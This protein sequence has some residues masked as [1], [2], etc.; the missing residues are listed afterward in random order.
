MKF[1]HLYSHRIIRFRRWSGKAYAAFCSIGRQVTIGQL[2][3]GIAEASLNKQRG[4][5]SIIG[6]EGCG[7]AEHKVSDEDTGTLLSDLQQLI[8]TILLPQTAMVDGCG[9]IASRYIKKKLGK[10][11]ECRICVCSASSLY[12]THK[13]C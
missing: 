10:P 9:A 12:I 6:E 8:A 3:K 1:V 11:S 2:T 5:V 4:I 13:I 7:S